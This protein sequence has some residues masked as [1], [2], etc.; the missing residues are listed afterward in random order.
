MGAIGIDSIGW[1]TANIIAGLGGKGAGVFLYNRVAEEIIFCKGSSFHRLIVEVAD[2]GIDGTCLAS[3]LI[4]V[5][6][7]FIAIGIDRSDSLAKG[8]IAMASGPL[9]DAAYFFF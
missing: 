2:R 6:A 8:I 1:L 3:K 5:K 4:V 7:S 9:L